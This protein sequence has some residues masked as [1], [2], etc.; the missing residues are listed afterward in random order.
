MM[1]EAQEQLAEHTGSV[2]MESP[3]SLEAGK[4]DGSLL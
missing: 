4:D 1:T 2:T 3:V